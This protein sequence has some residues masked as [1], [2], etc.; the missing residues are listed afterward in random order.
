MLFFLITCLIF[1]LILV[2][3][4]EF[5]VVTFD[6]N[7]AKT[8]GISASFFDFLLY[9]LLSLSIVIGI[10]AVGVILMSAMLIAP[11]VASRQFTNHFLL[12]IILLTCN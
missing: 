3:S 5:A 4:K 8:L 9:F 10:Q 2:F 1:L 6:R 12:M 7:Y 11:A